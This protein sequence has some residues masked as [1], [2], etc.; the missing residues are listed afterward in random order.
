MKLKIIHKLKAA[1]S[2]ILGRFTSVLNQLP[3]RNT[4]VRHSPLFHHHHY[5][6]ALVRKPH[7]DR[8]PIHNHPRDRKQKGPR[9][10]STKIYNHPRG[11]I[12]R[13]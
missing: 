4:K 10:S 12:R 13:G 2:S 5:A 7:V 11:D 8:S 6:Y 3:D 9:H 1:V